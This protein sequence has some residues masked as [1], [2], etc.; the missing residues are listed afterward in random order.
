VEV[1]SVQLAGANESPPNASPGSGSATVTFDLDLATMRLQT[2]FSGL[3]G[4]VTAAHIHCCT[5]DAG[6]GNVGVASQT[7]SFGGFPLGVTS[8]AYDQTFDL[9]LSSSYNA[10]FVTAN[11]SVSGA[12]NALLAGAAA[13]KAYLNIHTTTFGGGEIRGFL[14]PV[15]EPSS[16]ALLALGLLAVGAAARRRIS[17]T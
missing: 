5:A 3:T 15:P 12:M 10:A 4:T 2:S 6:A 8:G 1:Y 16:Y 9:S 7:P 13:G 14:A 11:G 17:A